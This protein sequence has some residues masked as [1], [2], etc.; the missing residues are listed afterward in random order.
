MKVPYTNHSDVYVFIGGVMIPP[1]DTREVDG[2]LMPGYGLPGEPGEK[3]DAP[4][5]ADPLVSILAGPVKGIL[6]GL[7]ALSDDEVEQLIALEN[8]SDKPRSS[9]LEGLYAELLRRHG[10]AQDTPTV[11]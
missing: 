7:D 11:A 5:A 8:G 10:T 6:A 9:L 1:G 3:G 4:V 2:R